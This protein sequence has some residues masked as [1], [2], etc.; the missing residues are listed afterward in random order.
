MPGW[1]YGG[2]RTREWARWVGRGGGEGRGGENKRARSPLHCVTKRA[3]RPAKSMSTLMRVPRCVKIPRRRN[4]IGRARYSARSIPLPV[5]DELLLALFFLFTSV[6]FLYLRPAIH[7]RRRW[8]TLFCAMY[9]IETK[10]GMWSILRT[11][12]SRSFTAS[13]NRNWLIR[14]DS[15][16]TT[17]NDII[18]HRY[19]F[20][21]Q[22]RYHTVRI[23]IPRNGISMTFGRSYSSISTSTA[24][25][26]NF[27]AC[28]AR[29]ADIRN[30]RCEIS[31]CRFSTTSKEYDKRRAHGA[32]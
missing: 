25:R 30:N 22:Y 12:Q 13:I 9:A 32:S 8:S 20:W 2:N 6:I 15:S 29:T 18:F 28:I 19:A 24:A 17:L 26:F 4:N 11:A 5:A 23:R 1:K 7:R 21:R 31:E 16:L 10:T 27:R 14:R 3:T